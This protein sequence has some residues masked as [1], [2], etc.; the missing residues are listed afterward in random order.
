LG[1]ALVLAVLVLGEPAALVAE[2]DAHYARRAEGA[3]GALALAGPADAAVASYRR[4]VAADPE[5]LLAR[6]RLVRALFF[7]STFVP[8]TPDERKALL[9]EARRIADEGLARVDRRVGQAKGPARLDA[10]R[11]IPQ[12]I[13]IHFWGAVAWGEWALT[14][15]KLAAARQGAGGRIRDLAQTVVDLDPA[16]EQGGGHRILGRLHDQ[17]PRIPFLTGWVSREKAVAF[18]RQALAQGPRNTLNQFFL[19]EALL[20]HQPEKK[21]EARRLLEQCATTAPRPEL[22]VEDAHYADLARRRLA[23][24]R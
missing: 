18:L 21:D 10:L 15:G 9:E 24:G 13:D 22:L 12:A 19:A 3:R 14:R 16:F 6:A 17:S 1:A 7:R 8:T 11:G 4:A 23:E 5:S 20:N 2:G